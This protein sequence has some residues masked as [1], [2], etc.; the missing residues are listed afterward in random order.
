M[1]FIQR[2]KK[3]REDRLIEKFNKE[4]FLTF[5]PKLNIGQKAIILEWCNKV[6]SEFIEHSNSHRAA[7]ED[8]NELPRDINIILNCIMYICDLTARNGDQE[9]YEAFRTIYIDTSRFVDIR[10]ED[11]EAITIAMHTIKKASEVVCESER[12]RI[13]SM[14]SKEIEILEQYYQETLRERKRIEG[15]IDAHGNLMNVFRKNGF[16]KGAE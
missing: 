14:A 1:S 10:P 6:A 16:L 15:A 4:G 5:T 7:V 13:L 8:S 2:I 3:I 12:D 11:K 9:Y